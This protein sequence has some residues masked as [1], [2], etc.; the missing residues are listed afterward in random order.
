MS[1]YGNNLSLF[2]LVVASCLAFNSKQH[3][4]VPGHFDHL[5]IFICCLACHVRRLRKFNYHQKLQ[6]K[7]N[8]VSNSQKAGNPIGVFIMGL[9][10]PL[11]ALLP[12]TTAP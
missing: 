3:C 5:I 4:Q 1:R 12:C 10:Q 9:S 11:V 7:L 2:S 8:G 6:E